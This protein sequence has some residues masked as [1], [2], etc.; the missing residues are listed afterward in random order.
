MEQ[1]LLVAGL[2]RCRVS[3]RRLCLIV[4]PELGRGW[5]YWYK[6]LPEYVR[7]EVKGR[8]EDRRLT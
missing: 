7:A 3:R 2:Q 6:P 1:F 8:D 5:I 4:F